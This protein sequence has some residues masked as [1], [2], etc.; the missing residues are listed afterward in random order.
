MRHETAVV[1]AAAPAEVW[2]V[3]ADVPNWPEWTPTVRSVAALDGDLRTG[4]RYRV[5]QPGMAAAVWE[6]VELEPGTS[7]GWAT[8][9]AGA[10]MVAGHWIR[11]VDAGAEVT[12]RIDFTGGFAGLLAPLVGGRIRRFVDTE[13]AAL[14]QT[15]EAPRQ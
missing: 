8:R 11:A 15:C 4:H 9:F 6:V 2:A 5:E 14:K 7:F 12:L 1:I 3:L 13:A 10:R